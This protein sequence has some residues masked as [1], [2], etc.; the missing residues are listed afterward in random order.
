MSDKKIKDNYSFKKMEY[1]LQGIKNLKTILKIVPSVLGIEDKNIEKNFKKIDDIKIDDIYEQFKLLQETPDKFNQYFSKLGWIAYESMNFDIMVKA[2]K[3]A[4]KN[5][6]EE[7]EKVLIDYYDNKDNLLFMISRLKGIEEFKP[8]TKLIYKALDDYIEGRYHA[9]VPVI[10]MMIDGFVNDIGQK[11]FFADDTDLSVWDSIAAHD[12]GLNELAKVLGKQRKKTRT[13]EIH[14]PYRHGI[15][16]GRDLGY[17]NKKTAIKTWATLF[18]LGDWARAIIAGK[19]EETKEFTP[20]TIEELIESI[21][22]SYKQIIQIQNEKKLINQFKQRILKPNV[23]FKPKGQIN[24]YQEG[25]PERVLVEYIQYLYKDNYG[26]MA[27]LTREL[28]SPNNSINKLAG[29]IRNIFQAKKLIDHEII[30]INHK[31]PAVTEIDTQLVFEKR[32]TS[33]ITIKKTFRLI[34]EDDNH[35]SLVR[36]TK[37]G[38]WKIILDFTDIEFL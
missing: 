30:S 18:A 37:G 7:A 19:K 32:N 2:V 10:L 14:L 38:K 1:N 3:L 9:C 34:Y 26:K 16:H 24:D 12:S 27:L 11:G 31:A 17:D 15:L 25:S 5:K 23:D 8:R 36:N 35:K 29:K 6:I 20:P 28:F 13:D 21:K 22:N 4:E 33:Q